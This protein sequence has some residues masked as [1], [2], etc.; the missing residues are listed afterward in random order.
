MSGLVGGLR[1]VIAYIVQEVS[2]IVI[3][4][5]E[6]PIGILVRWSLKEVLLHLNILL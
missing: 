1:E 5:M 6:E 4:L 3:W 2:L